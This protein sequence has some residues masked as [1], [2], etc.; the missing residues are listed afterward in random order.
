MDGVVEENFREIE[1]GLESEIMEC[2]CLWWIYAESDG[3]L[4]MKVSINFYIMDLRLAYSDNLG[5]GL[6]NVR[7]H[8]TVNNFS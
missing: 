3:L 6:M 1:S 8:V 5:Q 7:A 2:D 4:Q